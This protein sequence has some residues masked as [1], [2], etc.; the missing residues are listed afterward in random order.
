MGF[1]YAVLGAGRTGTAAAYDM[2]KFGDA[3]EVLLVDSVQAAAEASAELVNKLLNQ[4]IA[5]PIHADVSDTDKMNSV[6]EGVTA[7]LSAVPY[8]YN[9][10]LTEVAVRIGASMT[11]LG[12]NTGIVRK[13]LEFYNAAKEAGV[14]IVPD[15]GMGPGMN[16][17]LALYAMA[18]VD[19]PREVYIWD[20]GLPQEPKPPWN[21]LL[22]FN[23]G[24]LTNEYYDNAYFIRE[25]KVTEVPCFE[26]YELLD[27]PPPLHR[28]E[29]FVTSGGLS[30][31]PWT[32]EGKLESFE[33]KTLRYPGHCAQFKAFAQLGLLEQDPMKVDNI[34]VVPREV[35]HKLLEPKITSPEIKD[36]CII[37][38]KCVGEKSGQQAASVVEL[39]DYYDES[40]GFTAMQR[41][42]GWP[43][44][45]VTILAAQGKIERGA[46]P[47]ELAVPG[48]VMVEEA[49][50]RGFVIKEQVNTDIINNVKNNS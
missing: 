26:G 29:A 43:A 4:D 8:S 31:A 45:I 33:N 14:T 22:T 15:C 41:L 5:K 20:G 16:V 38:T 1:R 30:T 19:K 12:G 50:R 6:L 17:S 37:R 34:E 24:G 13:Q 39:I 18:L 44:S 42:T 23:I 27:F 21:Y 35:F 2:A 9:I 28:L 32:F 36:V 49:R 46:V 3:D 47:Y 11:D 40:T 10:S 48:E 25:G 7:F